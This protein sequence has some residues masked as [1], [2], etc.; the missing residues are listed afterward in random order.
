MGSASPTTS[1][2]AISSFETSRALT[3]SVATP[4]STAPVIDSVFTTSG[5]GVFSSSTGGAT[6]S[7][8]RRGSLPGPPHAKAPGIA[9][10]CRNAG[11]SVVETTLGSFLFSF[12]SVRVLPFDCFC[13]L[14]DD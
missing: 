6:L 14:V 2:F 12:S 3:I 8:D 11:C 9:C 4:A 7:N 1:W 13:S 5:S 10:T